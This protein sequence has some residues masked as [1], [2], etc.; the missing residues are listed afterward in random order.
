[1]V[2]CPHIHTVLTS[3]D[4]LVCTECGSEKRILMNF[5][6]YSTHMRT[7]PLNRQ[8][9]RPDRWTTLLRKILGMHSGPGTDDP[10]W[11][12]LRE[13]SPFKDVAALRKCI[14]TSGLPNK[15]YPNVHCFAKVFCQDYHTPTPPSRH[16]VT[17]AH[18][19]F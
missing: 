19:V 6:S 9:S 14:R 3:D 17:K 2:C 5:P 7:G 16:G 10:I 11:N 15:H 8:Y 13:H 18:Y 12:H 1:M 4:T